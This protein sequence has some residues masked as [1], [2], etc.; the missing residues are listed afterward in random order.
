MSGI[1]LDIY[2]F[3][4]FKRDNHACKLCTFMMNA[5]HEQLIGRALNI[6]K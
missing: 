1:T 4:I 3:M 5:L 2:L 6:S